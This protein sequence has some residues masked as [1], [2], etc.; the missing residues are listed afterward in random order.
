MGDVW[1]EEFVEGEGEAGAA[2]VADWPLSFF[3]SS[4]EDDEDVATSALC[5]DNLTVLLPVRVFHLSLCFFIA[6]LFAACRSSCCCLEDID[7]KRDS[8]VEAAEFRSMET[9]GGEMMLGGDFERED[10]FIMFRVR[11][12]VG[13]EFLTGGCTGWLERRDWI[14]TS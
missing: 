5:T 10:L 3:S 8:T 14:G 2:K 6:A 7:D 12:A 11:K 4:S 13:K 9:G 1:G